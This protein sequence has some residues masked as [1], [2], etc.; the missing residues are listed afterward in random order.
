MKPSTTVERVARTSAIAILGTVLMTGCGTET[1]ELRSHSSG[2][3]TVCPA[4]NVITDPPQ[5]QWTYHAASATN[6]TPYYSGTLEMGEAT[7]QIGS[8]TLTTRAYRQAGT[9]PR[10]WARP[11]R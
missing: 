7:F 11:S 6:P 10:S 8:N 5:F 1:E 2:S 9:A 3:L 4:T